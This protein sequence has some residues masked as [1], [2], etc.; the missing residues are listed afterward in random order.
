MFT[1]GC[2]SFTIAFPFT[3]TSVRSVPLNFH[4]GAGCRGG[5]ERGEQGRRAWGPGNGNI[6]G[7]E[8]NIHGIWMSRERP[9][10][11]NQNKT[12]TKQKWSQ[13]KQN[14]TKLE[15]TWNQKEPK[16]NQSGTK[17]K[18][19]W[20]G[21]YKRTCIKWKLKGHTQQSTLC[22]CEYIKSKRCV[23]LISDYVD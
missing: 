16:P 19:K 7:T 17:V 22:F 13:T 21:S 15:P 4:F 2:I 8:R 11:W 18:P 10:I 20:N 14:R 6:N 12:N 9:P 23:Q 1:H 3:I 5:L